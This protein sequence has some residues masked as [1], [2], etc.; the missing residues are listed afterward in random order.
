[1]TLMPV[2]SDRW[3]EVLNSLPETCMDYH[4][5]AIRLKDFRRLDDVTVVGGTIS[6]LTV[7]V[8]EWFSDE[9]IEDIL[10]THGTGA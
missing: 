9:E 3:A 10:V 7:N 5:V 8:P 4:I 1:M 2:L 6:R